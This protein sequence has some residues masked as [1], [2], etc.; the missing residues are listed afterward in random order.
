MTGCHISDLQLEAREI[1]F[2]KDVVPVGAGSAAAA[3]AVSAP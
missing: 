2:G 1:D 3:K